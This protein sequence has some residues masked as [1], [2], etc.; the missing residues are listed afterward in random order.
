M[1]VAQPVRAQAVSRAP[2]GRPPLRQ[3]GAQERRLSVADAEMRHG[4]KSRS[5]LVEGYT[6]HVLRDWDARLLVAVGGTPATEPEAH[7]T[8]ALADDLAAQQRPRQALPIDRASLASKLVQRR[9][10]DLALFCQAWPVRPGP[11]SSP[12]QYR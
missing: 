4:R 9:T 8:D 2:E 12:M 7:G 11:F 3:G 1:A 6:R 5:L 10:A